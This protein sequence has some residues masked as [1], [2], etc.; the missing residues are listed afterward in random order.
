MSF[1]QIIIAVFVGVS[2]A[3]V[4]LHYFERKHF[5]LRLKEKDNEFEDERRHWEKEREHLMSRFM[6]KTIYELEKRIELEKDRMDLLTSPVLA[7]RKLDDAIMK[8]QKDAIKNQKQSDG[9]N[10]EPNNDKIATEG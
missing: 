9:I 7:Q 6:D 1:E 8:E 10:M 4:L 3:S 2:V 5:A